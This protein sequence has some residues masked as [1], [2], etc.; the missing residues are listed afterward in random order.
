[1]TCSPDGV[2]SKA[3]CVRICCDQPGGGASPVST[4]FMLLQEGWH[5]ECNALGVAMGAAALGDTRLLE[6]GAA[7]PSALVADGCS[8]SDASETVAEAG[9]AQRLLSALTRSHASFGSKVAFSSTRVDAWDWR[10]QELLVIG[11]ELQLD[12]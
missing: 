10:T 7:R 9:A 6:A 1:M 8:G 4:W 3:L 11:V 2:G 12:G 5:E